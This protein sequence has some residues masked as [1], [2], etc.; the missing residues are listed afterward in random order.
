M[1]FKFNGRRPLVYAADAASIPRG[2]RLALV[3]VATVVAR[4]IVHAEARRRVRLARRLRARERR[5]RR[6]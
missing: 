5:V 6:R 1:R 4:L 3:E 2:R